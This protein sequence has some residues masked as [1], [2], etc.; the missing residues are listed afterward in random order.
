MSWIS[1]FL[2]ESGLEVRDNAD[3]CRLEDMRRVIISNGLHVPTPRDQS[4]DMSRSPTPPPLGLQAT[5]TNPNLG[6]GSAR[7][8]P[9]L[10]TMNLPP[11]ENMGF[12]IT[13]GIAPI[14]TSATPL[15]T[16]PLQPT[17]FNP[18]PFNFPFPF[19]Y[20]DLSN[21]SDNS[22]RMED[23]SNG[24][25]NGFDFNMFMN[26]ASMEDEEADG[27][28]QP[29]T[30]PIRGSDTDGEREDGPEDPEEEEDDET[31]PN[32]KRK[33]STIQT[34]HQQ[35][36]EEEEEEE[37]EGEEEMDDVGE[38][39]EEEDQPQH[40]AYEN[41]Y[42]N[43]FNTPADS[44]FNQNGD[45]EDYFD[46][47][48]E[49]EDLFL[50]IEDVPIPPS[51]D[52]ITTTSSSSSI[53]GDSGPGGDVTTDLMKALNVNTKDQLAALMQKLVDS[54]SSTDNSGKVVGAGGEG[55]SRDVVEKLKNVIM[56]ARSKKTGT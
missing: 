15:H 13:N 8:S 34:Q 51:S 33:L 22:L 19:N 7:P 18:F 49:D 53:L 43:D 14:P 46:P 23:T 6:N 17:D 5:S 1:F 37:G 20:P 10:S 2:A 21:G 52:H 39:E 54:T 56:M 47:D 11:I 35:Q 4:M 32:P 28:F 29:E 30:S 27:D 36:Q 24:S 42:E 25:D 3:I 41:E 55:V 48:V 50:P 12:P 31:T 16:V 40:D 9:I 45:E 38:Q 44:L 26:M